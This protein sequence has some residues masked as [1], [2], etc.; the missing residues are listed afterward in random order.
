VEHFR[1]I[2]SGQK[3]E[4]RQQQNRGEQN[5]RPDDLIAGKAHKIVIRNS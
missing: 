5:K 1:Y 2:L 3:P 4:N